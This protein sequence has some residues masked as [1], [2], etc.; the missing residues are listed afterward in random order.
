M[1]DDRAKIEQGAVSRSEST[2]AFPS[3]CAVVAR[4]GQSNRAVVFRDR[5]VGGREPST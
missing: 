4:G 2:R 1:R 3:P 5:F